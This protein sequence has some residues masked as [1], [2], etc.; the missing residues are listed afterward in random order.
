MEF[1]PVKRWSPLQV[2]THSFS[3][4]VHV[5]VGLRF[6]FFHIYFINAS[7]NLPSFSFVLFW[8]SA[9]LHGEFYLRLNMSNLTFKFSIEG[10]YLGIFGETVQ[11]DLVKCYKVNDS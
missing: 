2:H 4:S 8:P 1:D 10:L 3:H 9:N 11:P 5:C 7:D 6:C